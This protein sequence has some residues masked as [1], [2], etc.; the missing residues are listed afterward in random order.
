MKKVLIALLI[1][2]LAVSTVQAGDY[3]IN[4]H[5]LHKYLCSIG[6]TKYCK[7]KPTP[8]CQWKPCK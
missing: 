5:R 8:H 7:G 1:A 4:G 2:G 3:A 6:L